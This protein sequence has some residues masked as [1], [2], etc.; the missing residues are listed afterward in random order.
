M[1]ATVEEI[2]EFLAKVPLFKPLKKRQLE[3]LA[4]RVRERDYSAGDV[5]VEQGVIG[6]GL[7][8]VVRGPVKVIRIH[9]D[10]TQRQVSEL[11]RF[12]FFGELSLLEDAVRTASVIADADSKC[13]VLSKL[14]FLDELEDDP[15][16]AVPM[17]KEIAQRFRRIMTNL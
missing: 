8:V 10:G 14:D 17:L 11:D 13:L 3:K 1:A 9:A 2:A 15:A 5:I 4:H 6:I 7:F 16:M 12:D